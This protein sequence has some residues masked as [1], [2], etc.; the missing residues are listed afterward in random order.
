LRQQPGHD[1]VSEANAE[2]V[3]PFE[4]SE[5]ISHFQSHSKSSS[6]TG[7]QKSGQPCSRQ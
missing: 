7:P 3:A 4:F 2:D 5:K 6:P 1:H